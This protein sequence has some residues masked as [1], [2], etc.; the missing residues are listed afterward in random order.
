MDFVRHDLAMSPGDFHALPIE[1]SDIAGFRQLLVP[2]LTTAPT[3][4]LGS[5]QSI[6][7][8]DGERCDELGIDI[9]RRRSGGGAVLVSDDDVVWF[10]LV[11]GP[12][13]PLW[14]SDVG[15]AFEWVGEACQRSLQSL[16]VESTMH[17]G[18]LRAHRWSKA[19]CFA[20]VGPGELLEDGR[21]IVGIS[22]RRTRNFARFQVAILRRWSGAAH[23]AL[24]RVPDDERKSVAV[25]LDRVATGVDVSREEFLKT[26]ARQLP[27]MSDRT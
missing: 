5:T 9:V 26:L 22:Q 20:G 16:G 8:I 21:K 7:S 14:R 18:N 11:I 13:D 24:L 19:V 1:L 27:R 25:E 6:E 23:A 4:V 17:I 15:R 12:D 3:L 10:D 2:S